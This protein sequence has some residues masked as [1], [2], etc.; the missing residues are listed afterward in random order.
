[1]QPHNEKS[2]EGVIKLNKIESICCAHKKINKNHCNVNTMARERGKALK[3][4]IHM[5]T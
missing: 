1:L 2:V 4:V 3:D 5:L